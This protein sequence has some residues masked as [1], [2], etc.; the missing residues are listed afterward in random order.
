[1]FILKGRFLER[2]EYTN[3]ENRKVQ[4][5]VIYSEG[6]GTTYKLSGFNDTGLK[7]FD[8]VSI[9]VSVGVY[10]GKLYLR[11]VEAK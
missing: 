1:M 9:P 3:K 4:Q 7:P 11:V 2:T 10:D 6:D 8:P 5:S